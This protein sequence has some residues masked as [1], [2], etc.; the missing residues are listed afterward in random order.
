MCVHTCSNELDAVAPV[1]DGKGCCGV[2][3]ACNDDGLAYAGCCVD[4]EVDC[5]AA[6]LDA[7]AESRRLIRG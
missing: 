2:V 5:C 1:N 6:L 3:V 7:S 4:D